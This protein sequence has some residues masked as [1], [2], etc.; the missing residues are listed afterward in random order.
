MATIYHRGSGRKSYQIISGLCRGCDY[1]ATPQSN[2][3]LT[4]ELSSQA[5]VIFDQ[6]QLRSLPRQNH[7]AQIRLVKLWGALMRPRRFAWHL[8]MAQIGRAFY[9]RWRKGLRPATTIFAFT[10]IA[11]S[12]SV[13]LADEGGVS[14]WIPGLYGSL[15]AAPQVPGWA[16]GFVNLYNPVSAGGN[17]AAARQ[18]TINKFPITV[19]VNLNAALKANP[20]L[21][22]VN[23]TY[24]FATPVF[25]GQ[26][27]L[28]MAG[29]VGRSIAELN[30][31]LTAT[32][33]PLTVTRQGTIED[34]RDVFSDLYPEATLRW[35]NGVN[36]WMTY[37]MGDIPVGTYDSNN[38]ANGSIG[39]GAIDSG[40]GY[41]YFNP[42]T[43]HEFSVVTGLTYNLVNP[44][45]G[46]QNGID[47][48]LDWAASQFL[49]KTLHI[50]P[51]TDIDPAPVVGYSSSDLESFATNLG[52]D[53]GDNTYRRV[54]LRV[55]SC[56]GFRRTRSNGI[57]PLQVMQILVGWSG[58]CFYSLEARCRTCYCGDR[59]RR[60]VPKDRSQS[61]PIL[62]KMRWPPYGQ[63]PSTRIG[64]RICSDTADA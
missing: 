16:I 30:G 32:A 31:T 15:A 18:V 47:W 49:T 25:G 43:G 35:N 5:G 11:C 26:F 37:G 50:G 22:L 9:D 20:N 48:H 40:V 64:R 29:A 21:I 52:G 62:P 3:N 10:A 39:H 27:A 4:A 33:G 6:G 8:S 28:N 12:T 45:T 7:L 36:N 23:P 38:L 58:Q 59:T 60:H 56:R 13:S 61:A 53:N 51:K 42:Q 19:N 46:Y 41:T 2:H 55:G 57:L 63:S 14:F 54:L 34:G 17:V 1:Q 44:S 24:V